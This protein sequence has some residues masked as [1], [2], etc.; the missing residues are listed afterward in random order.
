MF[1]RFNP[2]MGGA[3][4]EEARAKAAAAKKEASAPVDLDKV[5]IELSRLAAKLSKQ[6][7][8]AWLDSDKSVLAAMDDTDNS[9]D[10]DILANL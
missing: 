6:D 4:G 10:E 8:R 2:K 3:Q 5:F 7:L 1:V 9:S